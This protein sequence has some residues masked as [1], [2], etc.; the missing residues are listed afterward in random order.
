MLRN[1]HY[2]NITE[3]YVRFWDY[4]VGIGYASGVNEAIS[5]LPTV[6]DGANTVEVL[7]YLGLGTVVM[8]THAETGVNLSYLKQSGEPDGDAG[9]GRMV[10]QRW[11]SGSNTDVERYDYGVDPSELLKKYIIRN[12]PVLCLDLFLGWI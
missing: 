12:P 6:A 9:F 10:D 2:P 11:V 7:S 3:Y 4:E 8:R 5:R 1:I